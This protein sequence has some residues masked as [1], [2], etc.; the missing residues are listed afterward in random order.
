MLPKIEYPV[1]EFYV[2]SLDRKVKFR[3]FLVKEEKIL[4][5][6]K[7]SEDETAINT[8]VTQI[9]NNCAM[10]EIDVPSLPMFDIEMIFLKLRAKSVGENVKLAFNCKNEVDGKVC[11]TNTDYSLN[12]DKIE[13]IIPEGHTNKI[14]ITDTIGV[15]MKYPSLA[16]M[17][18]IQD[19]DEFD[20]MI[21]NLVNC[22]DY[23][24]NGESVYKIK[25]ATPE[26]QEEFIE[27]FSAES[28]EN[29][30]NFFKSSPK[31][32]LTDTVRCKKCGFVHELRAEDLLSFFV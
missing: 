27:S 13:Y 16:T 12:L 29:I 8:A 19:M 10:E 32:V 28:M 31:V 17:P 4:L 30:Q 3:P 9:I 26:E 1:Y 14:M 18:V 21:T 24:F 25:D 22:I 5:M 2:K 7:E 6:A 15:V 23:V 11:D 20:V